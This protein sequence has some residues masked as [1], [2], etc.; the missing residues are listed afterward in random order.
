MRSNAKESR[1]QAYLLW[2]FQMNHILANL[3][4]EILLKQE[5]HVVHFKHYQLQQRLN[6]AFQND[7]LHTRSLTE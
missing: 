3:A 4:K 5:A 2:V 6:E 1:S 7:K